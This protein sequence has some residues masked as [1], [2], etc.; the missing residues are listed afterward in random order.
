M[1]GWNHAICELCWEKRCFALGQPG[2]V[3]VRVLKSPL[4]PCCFCDLLTDWGAFVRAKP[5]TPP[6]CKGHE[7]DD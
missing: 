3:A 1:S 5:G 2:R 4:E 7:D 6:T